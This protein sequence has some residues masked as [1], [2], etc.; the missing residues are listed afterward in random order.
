MGLRR[1]ASSFVA[2]PSGPYV[3]RA[4]Q[5][6][7]IAHKD[8]LSARGGNT[9]A[10]FRIRAQPRSTLAHRRVAIARSRDATERDAGRSQCTHVSPQFYEIAVEILVP[11]GTIA[12]CHEIPEAI[13]D[14]RDCGAFRHAYSIG[15]NKARIGEPYERAR[16]PQ[17]PLAKPR[18]TLA[19]G[20]V[21]AGRR[22]ERPGRRGLPFLPVRLAHRRAALPI[23]AAL[24]SICSE[25]TGPITARHFSDNSSAC[26][27]RQS[28]I[29]PPPGSTP[30]HKSL[31]WRAILNVCASAPV[32]M[33]RLQ[34]KTTDMANRI[35]F[36]PLEKRR[37]ERNAH[38]PS[39][40]DAATLKAM[41]I[42][43]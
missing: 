23:L 6:A 32:G 5:F 33:A 7:A 38:T 24:C 27:L 34:K 19:V 42:E 14:Q 35:E 9:K 3:P 13:I 22:R 36:P 17:R 28:R 29:L 30:A 18:F 40:M 11:I 41:L 25:K 21:P 16:K 31:T 37:G 12:A 2:Q 20:P 26:I 15:T 1:G 39:I 10:R 4:F 8:N 43:R